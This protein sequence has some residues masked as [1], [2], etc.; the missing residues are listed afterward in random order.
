MIAAPARNGTIFSVESFLKSKPKASAMSPP[1]CM[2]WEREVCLAMSAA[3]IAD[4]VLAP[5][6]SSSKSAECS[7]EGW[8][9]SRAMAAA[10]GLAEDLALP[11]SSPGGSSARESR[12]RCFLSSTASPGVSDAKT[13]RGFDAA[14]RTI[15]KSSFAGFS[16]AGGD[17]ATAEFS[18]SP[19]CRERNDAVVWDTPATCVARQAQRR[20]GQEM[21]RRIERQQLLGA[22]QA[23]ARLRALLCHCIL[24]D[25]L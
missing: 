2:V 12:E 14:C 4:Q 10:A 21:G 22:L 20:H 16:T 7:A 17:A 3:V 18:L 6:D 9:L 15:V 25:L 13:S 8:A 1:G 5:L 11:P 19:F 24:A 23:L